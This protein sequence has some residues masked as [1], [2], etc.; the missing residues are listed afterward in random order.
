V[1]HLILF[2]HPFQPKVGRKVRYSRRF[3]DPEGRITPPAL[4]R[5]FRGDPHE[6]WQLLRTEAYNGPP[7]LVSTQDP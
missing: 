4:R 5:A 6:G 7:S 2:H 1:R 3:W